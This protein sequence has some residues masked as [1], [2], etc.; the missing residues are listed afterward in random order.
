MKMVNVVM[1]RDMLTALQRRLWQM[2]GV[3]CVKA[4][5]IKKQELH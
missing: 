1:V 3:K 4:G 2:E 5:G